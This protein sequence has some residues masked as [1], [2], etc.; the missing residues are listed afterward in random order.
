MCVAWKSH[1]GGVRC[2]EVFQS[3]LVFSRLVH[4][5][6]GIMSGFLSAGYAISLHSCL[7]SVSAFASQWVSGLSPLSDYTSVNADLWVLLC[8]QLHEGTP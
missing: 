8:C 7:R 2:D 5:R 3:G 1:R 6:A 4:A